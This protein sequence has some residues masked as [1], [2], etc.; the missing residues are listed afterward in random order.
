MTLNIVILQTDNRPHLNYLLLTQEVNK[1]SC[2]HLGYKYEFLYLNNEKYNIDPKTAKLYIVNEYLQNSTDDILIFLDSDAWVQN[3]SWLKDMIQDLINDTNKHG[4]F[5]RDPYVKKNTFI[6]SGSFILKINEYTKKM[7]KEIIFL[8][9][10]D[11]KNNV[12]N[13]YGWEDQFYVSNYVFQNKECFNIFIP[14]TINTPLGEVIRHNW[15]KTQKMV[16]DLYQL[17][18]QPVISDMKP[19]DSEKYYDKEIY[20]NEPEYGNEYIIFE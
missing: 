17:I 7:Y 13:K 11:I 3:P 9:E 16:N 19:F 5:S 4:C 18:N 1:K 6:N 20:P 10:N 15:W 12:F 8:L 14:H 2:S